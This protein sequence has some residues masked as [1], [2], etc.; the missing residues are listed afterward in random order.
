MESNWLFKGG[1]KK[2]EIIFYIKRIADLI[3]PSNE[4]ILLSIQMY[5]CAS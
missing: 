5:E 1:E 3:I 2:G 4:I